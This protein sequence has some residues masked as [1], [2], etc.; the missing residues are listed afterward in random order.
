MVDNIDDYIGKYPAEVQEILRE[1]RVS[2][3]SVAPETV[4]A[5]AYGI[6]T[7]KYKDKNLV[8]F[9]GFKKHVG[10]YPV[11][12]GMVA[13]EKELRDYKKAKGSVQF[14]LNKPIPHELI[15]E[16]TKFRIAEIDKGSR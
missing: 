6:P 5:I 8:H 4:E 11:P 13:F 10:F 1:V 2:I 3:K 9:G 12:S 7:F 16:I 14:P 15:K